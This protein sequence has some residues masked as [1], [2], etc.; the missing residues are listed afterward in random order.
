MKRPGFDCT[1]TTELGSLQTPYLKE[2]GVYTAG[3][4]G[5]LNV[6][7]SSQDFWYATSFVGGAGPPRRIALLDIK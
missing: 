1:S 3:V 7:C 5:F 4:Q 6:K 2:K